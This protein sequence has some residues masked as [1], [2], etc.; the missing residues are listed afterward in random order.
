LLVT[1]EI[2]I[3]GRSLLERFREALRA[4]YREGCRNSENIPALAERWVKAVRQLSSEDETQ[5]LRALGRPLEGEAYLKLKRE[6]RRQLLTEVG[7][8]IGRLLG[9]ARPAG[10]LRRVEPPQK[11]APGVN[12]GTEVTYVKGVG[13][14]MATLL[15]KVGVVTVGDLIGLLPRRWEDRTRIVSASGVQDGDT[16]VVQGKL[17]KLS[18]RSPRQGMSIVT[19]PLYTV[20]G[21]V[22]LIWFN[23][24][25]ILS[26]LK[27]GLEVFAFGK[28]EMKYARPQI[29]SPELEGVD[30]PHRLAGR[31][32]PIYPATAR[33]S[34]KWLRSLMMQVVP[35]LAP[36]LPDPIPASL[37]ARHSFLDRGSAVLEYHFPTH[38]VG[39]SQARRRLAYEELFLLQVELAVQRKTRELEPRQTTY[40][41]DRMRAEDF[42]ELLPFAPTGAQRRV[43]LEIVGDLQARVP[44]NRLLQGDVGSG[45]TVIAAFAAWA[46]IRQGYQA[47]IMAPT[48]ILAEQHYQKLK[49]LMAPAGIRL[50]F[51]S[52]SLRK[53]A[54]DE[55][56]KALAAHEIDLAVGTHALLQPDVNFARL[57]LAVV[58]EQHKFG[59]LQRTLLRQ[60]GYR[61]N[62]DLLVMTATPIPRTLALTVHGELEVSKLDELPPGRTPIRSESVRFSARKR[63]YEEIKAELRAGRQAYVVCPMIDEQTEVDKPTAELTSAKAEYKVLAEQVFQEFS[64]GLLHGQMKAVEKEAVMESFRRGEFQVLVATTVI[65]VG[66]DVPNA[67]IMLVQDADR[68]GLSQLHQLRGRVGRGAHQS[69]CI[70]MADTRSPDSQRR[71]KAIAELSDGFEVAEEDLQIRGPGDYFGLRQSGIP[72]FQVADLL[73]DIDLVQWAQRDAQELV[74]LDPELQNEPV[75]RR[76][77]R[78][79]AERTAELVH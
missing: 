29:N 24:K 11:L 20:D 77:L 26:S 8:Q 15:E 27:T 31:W 73:Q 34:Q 4:E 74:D 57:A 35:S 37:R 54:K 30:E 12:L 46:A 22:D 32:V 79:R 42:F 23:Q 72:D 21:V 67:T 40:R 55:M 41:S 68:F 63:I 44:M 47:S 69:R 43:A 53:K 64:V 18:T 9:E 19:C 7:L 3:Q 6:A 71:L 78:L 60:K 56:K 61:H 25:W 51:L 16:V 59:V 58:D 17:G 75:L 28:V 1:V 50:G 45:K 76:S 2:S 38:A 52:G 70:F 39:L 62:P 33:M 48:E 5:H 10:E 14:K 65:E 66:V 36:Q 13:P 49:Q